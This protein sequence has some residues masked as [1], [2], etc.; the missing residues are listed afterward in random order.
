MRTSGV[1]VMRQMMAT[2]EHPTGLGA[3][4]LMLLTGFRRK[5]AL[6]LRR[7]WRNRQEHAIHFPTTKSGEH[8]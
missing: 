3:I 7:A 1:K 5:E 4:R 2:G 8:P 6:S